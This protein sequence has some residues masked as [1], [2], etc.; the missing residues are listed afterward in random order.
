MGSAVAGPGSLGDGPGLVGTRAGLHERRA[1]LPPCATYSIVARCPATG[2]LGA[3]AQSHHF[4]VGAVA[5]WAQ[6]G[7]GVV[8]TQGF[9]ERSY[10]PRGLEGMARGELAA[11]VLHRLPAEDPG[12]AL[13]QVALLDAA[14][15][16]AYSPGL[17]P[18]R[19][20]RFE[21]RVEIRTPRR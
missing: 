19:E 6:A 13:R 3:A 9:A 15:R 10:R 18:L 1:M 7:V 14:G 2:Q 5:T 11:D 4:G 17:G 21:G 12:S 20:P 8:A 16:S